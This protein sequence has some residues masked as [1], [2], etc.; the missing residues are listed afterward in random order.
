[1][2]LPAL[3]ISIRQPWRLVSLPPVRAAVSEPAPTRPRGSGA[4]PANQG[5]EILGATG[6]GS[7]PLSTSPRWFG[8]RHEWLTEA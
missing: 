3:W 1:M 8:G 2:L 7:P 4:A 5:I 6:G